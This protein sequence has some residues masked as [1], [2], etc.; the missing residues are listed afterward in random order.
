MAVTKVSYS[1][2]DESEEK[3][4][5]HLR[6]P[7]IASDGSNWAAVANATTGM[8]AVLGTSLGTLTRLNEYRSQLNITVNDVAPSAPSDEHAQREIAAR[9]TYADDVTGDLYRFD[10]PGP[11]SIFLA[12]TD[13]VDMSDVAVAA[14][15]IVFEADVVSP[16]GNS[17]T[18]LS[19]IRVGKNT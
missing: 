19:G 1:Y 9:F 11:E 10:V 2:V 16:A 3:C 15:K 7:E 17:V 8:I 18:L 13:K 4:T 5:L 6:L 14:F 12:G